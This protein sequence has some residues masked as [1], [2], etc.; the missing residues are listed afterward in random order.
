LTFPIDKVQ[1]EPLAPAVYGYCTELT[2]E[3]WDRKMWIFARVAGTG[4]DYLVLGGYFVEKAPK[5]VESQQL[6]VD[7]H[8][9]VLRLNGSDCRLIGPADE[10]FDYKPD[11]ISTSD[12]QSLAKDAVCRYARAFGGKQKFLDALRR[13]HVELGKSPV[14]HDALSTKC[15]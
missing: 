11:Q 3:R 4:G 1:F 6:M 7:K 13:Q 10:V 9:V 14:L 2:N 8:G 15:E 5:T 12:L